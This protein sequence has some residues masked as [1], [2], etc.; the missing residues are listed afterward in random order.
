MIITKKKKLVKNLVNDH[1]N[2]R[3]KFALHQKA[4]ENI[5]Y[6]LIKIFTNKLKN[7]FSLPLE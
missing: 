3:F 6:N 1:Q 2:N 5:K 7:D 4:C